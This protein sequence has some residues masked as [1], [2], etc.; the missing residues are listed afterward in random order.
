MLNMSN[1]AR[2]GHCSLSPTPEG[3]STWLK[4]HSTNAAQRRSGTARTQ[5]GKH[6]ACVWDGSREGGKGVVGITKTVSNME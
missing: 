4:E 3:S 5:P 1:F 6:G 2:H